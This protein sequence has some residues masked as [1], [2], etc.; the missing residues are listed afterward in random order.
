[1]RVQGTGPAGAAS[2]YIVRTEMPRSE[3]AEFAWIGFACL[4]HMLALV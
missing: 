2:A 4:P 1:M 3:A